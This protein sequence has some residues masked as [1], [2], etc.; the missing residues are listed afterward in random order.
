[1][2]NSEAK[3]LLTV[4][5]DSP[6]LEILVIDDA[7]RI[8]GR[9][10]ADQAGLRL[11]LPRGLYTVRSLLSG[12][13]I[14]TAIRLDGP[15]TLRAETPEVFSA[16]TFPGARTTHDYYAAPALEASLRMTA[17]TVS[18]S[19]DA[20]LLLFARSPRRE[21]Y[22]GEDLFS[23][24]TLRAPNGKV[25]SRLEK[26]GVERG[27]EGWAAFST[28][29]PAGQAIIEDAGT[30]SRRIPVPLLHGRQ[31]QIFVMHHGRLLWED[32]RPNM[33]LHAPDSHAVPLDFRKETWR[34]ASNIDAG[35]LALQNHA[36]TIAPSLINAFV[37]TKFQN[38]IAGL[39]G[40]YLL[41]L[42]G[43]RGK[44]ISREYADRIRDVLDNLRRLL[45]ES[46]DVAALEIM[47]EPWL[48]PASP[49][50]ILQ[51]PFFRHGTKVL[52]RA[53]VSAPE[54]LPPESLLAEVADHLYADSTWTTWAVPKPSS[55]S[56]RRFFT[57]AEAA[58]PDWVELAVIDALEIDSRTSLSLD[59]LIRKMAI[60]PASAQKAMERLG[61]RVR[62]GQSIPELSGGARS[63]LEGILKSQNAKG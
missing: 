1:M 36:Y 45:P 52:L 26:R 4:E 42:D 2:S 15:R 35:L 59:D 58:E 38:P 32:M 56:L 54:W 39:L 13:F 61:Q 50:P 49:R 9:C 24:I 31:T 62:R 29:L 12:T 10:A 16:A 7:G 41:L 22:K 40:A 43:L 23:N 8:V 5:A 27:E 25:L 51:A 37:D 30:P 53:A 3:F 20:G 28:S 60:P 14:D 18:R 57:R 19:A 55:F 21:S 17:R 11:E 48:G 44:K 47:A 46:A 34:S 63:L 33:V 6:G